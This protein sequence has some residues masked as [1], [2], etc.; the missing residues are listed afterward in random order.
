M[1]GWYPGAPSGS[2]WER[3]AYPYT[4]EDWGKEHREETLWPW[5]FGKYDTPLPPVSRTV[6]F[7]VAEYLRK[8]ASDLPL[9]EEGIEVECPHCGK[10]HPTF[11][12][13]GN[14]GER[15]LVYRYLET[16][17]ENELVAGFSEGQRFRLTTSLF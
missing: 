16:S 15:L 10:R 3:I 13:D 9:V 17:G 7:D 5:K 6:A 12:V 4:D 11:V 8:S 14:E 1:K 2:R